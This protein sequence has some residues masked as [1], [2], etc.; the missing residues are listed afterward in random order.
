MKEKFLTYFVVVE[1]FIGFAWSFDKLFRLTVKGI[2]KLLC[3][4]DQKRTDRKYTKIPIEEEK[5][6]F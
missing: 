6:E 1:L 4:I 3:K 2:G 5:E